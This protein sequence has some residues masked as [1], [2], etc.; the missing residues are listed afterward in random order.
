MS[1][2]LTE[3]AKKLPVA[4]RLRLVEE[5]WNSIAEENEFLELTDDQ[6]NELDRRLKSSSAGRRWEEIRAEFFETK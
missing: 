2:D 5:I 3:R 6:K 1:T 4:E